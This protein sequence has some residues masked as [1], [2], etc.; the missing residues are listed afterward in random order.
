MRL[1]LLLVVALTLFATT[2]FANSIQ[3]GENGVT[4][5]VKG[6]AAIDL[7]EGANDSSSITP[8]SPV[9]LGDIG[10]CEPG[11]G[12]CPGS[13][14]GFNPPKNVSDWVRFADNPSFGG[15]VAIFYSDPYLPI[16]IYGPGDI[17][18]MIADGYAQPGDSMGNN[19]GSILMEV[20]PPTPYGS[21]NFWSDTEHTPEPGSLMLFGTG[22][23]SIGGLLRRK[24][25][26]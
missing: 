4:K 12:G 24:I 21:Y 16:F 10:L 1:R 15:Y 9:F 20:G 5:I 8:L 7:F 11:T 13:W 25:G 6:P 14:E 17:A 26:K 3:V 19:S 23:L 18:L 2:A 22:L